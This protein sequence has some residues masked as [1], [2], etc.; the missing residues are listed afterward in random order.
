[1]MDWLSRFARLLIFRM[2]ARGRNLDLIF[3]EEEGAGRESA[4]SGSLKCGDH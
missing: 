2:G 1:M 4:H 3:L